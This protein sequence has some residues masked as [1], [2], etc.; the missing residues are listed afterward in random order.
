M[1]AEAARIIANL[2]PNAVI[3]VQVRA[4]D[5]AKA[6][7]EK[8]G[9]PAELSPGQAAKRFGRSAKYWR[10]K[11]ESGEVAGAYK[12]EE[13]DRWYLPNASCRAHLTAKAKPYLSN[14]SHRRSVRRGPRAAQ[15]QAP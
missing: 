5:Y 15:T 7:E 8:T 3:T 11:A 12:D 9:G 13:T 6:L 1:D 10:Q 2:D 4:A 14:H